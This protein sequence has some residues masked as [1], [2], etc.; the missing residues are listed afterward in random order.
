MKYIFLIFLC[1]II[2]SEWSNAQISGNSI[3]LNGTSDWVRVPNTSSLNI[4][5]NLTMEAWIYPCAVSGYRA[6]MNKHWCAGDEGQFHLGIRDGYLEMNW[7]TASGNCGAPNSFHSNSPVISVNQWYHVAIVHTNSSNVLY[8]NG[9]PIPGSFVAGGNSSISASGSPFIIGVY[10]GISGNYGNYFQG[11]IDDVRVWNIAL[12]NTQISSRYNVALAGS[13]AGLVA[14]YHMEL[15]GMGHNL[16]IPNNAISTGSTNNGTTIGGGSSPF[17]LDNSTVLNCNNI[18]TNPFVNFGNDTAICNGSNL[19]LNPGTGYSS[20]TWQ[21]NSTNNFF[22]VVNPGKYWVTVQNGCGT[23]SDT[24][25]ISYK[26]IQALNLGNDTL[27]CN[28]PNVLLNAKTGFITYKWNNNSTDSTL[29]IST[30][31][32]YWVTV[33]NS[34]GFTSDTIKINLEVSPNIYLGNDTSICAGSNFSLNAGSGFTSYSW[35]DNSTNNSFNVVNPG[36]YW[37][38]VQNGCGTASDTI[39]ISYKTIQALNLGNDTLFCNTPNVLLNAKTGFITYK[40]NNNSTDS[41][42]NISTSGKY[43]VT[44]QN[45]CGLASDTVKINFGVSPNINLGND[46]SICAGSNLS[47]DAGSGFTSYTWQDNSINNS[48]N[49][50]NPGKYWVT[51]QNGCGM[52]SDTIN[53]SYKTIQALNLG[54]DR[55]FCNTPNVLL[56]AKTGFITYKWNNNSTDSTLNISS[57][58]K[59]WVTVQNSCGFA[60]DTIKINLDT[61]PNIYLGN[62]TSICAG[63][64]FSLNAGSGFTSYS[65]QDNSTNDSFN[66]ENPGKYWVTVQNSCGSSSDTINIEIPQIFIPN[67]ITPNHDNLND[68]FEIN[69]SSEI[70]I[71]FFNIW[72]S[73]IYKNKKYQNDWNGNNLPGG[74]YLYIVY[75]KK[76]LKE[77]KGWFHMVK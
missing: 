11:R 14:Y 62:D 36:K 4:T 60:S 54:N 20:Y 28:T 55:L 65:W 57:S 41:T 24:I 71:E 77:Y 23:A 32:K 44:V 40:W 2:H 6:I 9:N 10:R 19:I 15:T 42:L 16:I 38:T 53:I 67:L 33:Q 43:W 47:L 17:F 25:N 39:N 34:C 22:N 49:V 56:N 21:D 66:L 7:T 76:C 70:D 26:T 31:G 72:G 51:V 1:V 13:E 75:D 30:S 73:S 29:N 18:C 58:G 68:A 12:T 48:F 59:Y 69:Y 52:A 35:Q 61:S 8:L 46:T 27:F 5:G 64:N 37:V 63:S 3:V 74:L 45:S 50:V